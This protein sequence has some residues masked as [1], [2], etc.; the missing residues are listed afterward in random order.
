[1]RAV[2]ENEHGETAKIDLDCP[3]TVA[4]GSSGALTAP[5]VGDRLTAAL[6]DANGDISG[7]RWQWQRGTVS[8]DSW[9][10]VSI[11]DANRVSYMLT[12]ADVGQQVRATVSYMDG[13][14]DN[15]DTAALTPPEPRM[16]PSA[17]TLLTV[18]DGSI[19][20]RMCAA[21]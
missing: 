11:A 18:P 17:T 20:M 13:A 2:T 15:T 14:G 6:T 7:Q 19:T 9:T 1:M 3:G 4:L 21:S 16:E 12:A 5:R 10:G 8:G